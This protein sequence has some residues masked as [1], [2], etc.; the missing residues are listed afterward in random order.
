MPWSWRP[1]SAG[2]CRAGCRGRSGSTWPP[3]PPCS[4]AWAWGCGWPA[5]WPARPAPTWRCGWPTCISTCSGGSGWPSSGPSSRCGRRCCGPAWCRGWSGRCAGRCRRWPLGLA[6]AAGGL[7][8]QR[9]VVALAGLVGTRRDWGSRWSRSSAR[10]CG[11]RRARRRPGCSGPGWPGSRS[12]SWPTWAPCRQPAGG[13]P[14]RPLAAGWSPSVVAGFALQTLIGALTYLLP[15]V[16]GRGAYG[17][18]RLTADPRAG[19]AV[20]G[21]RRQPRGAA[22]GRWLAPAVGWWLAG[23]GLASFVPLAV[24]ALVVATRRP[25]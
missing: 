16:F 23:I 3:R 17:N 25:S 20:A 13:R 18:R 21:R 5:G 24:V 4:P 1:G 11:G 8:T 19:L 14:G 15:V 7:A 2:P 12:R 22:A 9:R 6:V 10:R